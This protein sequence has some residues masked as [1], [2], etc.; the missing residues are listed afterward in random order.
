[1]MKKLLFALFTILSFQ[2][3]SQSA[4]E[5]ANQAQNL[6]MSSEEDILRELQRRGMTVQDAERMALIYGK[7]ALFHANVEIF[8]GYKKKVPFLGYNIHSTRPRRMKIA[9]NS[10]GRL[11]RRVPRTVLTAPLNHLIQEL[12]YQGCGTSTGKPIRNTRLVHLEQDQ[13]ISFEE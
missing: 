13:I 4:S 9:Y 1:M 12:S 6:G 5:I 11:V 8:D 3:Y 2:T 10:S 7:A